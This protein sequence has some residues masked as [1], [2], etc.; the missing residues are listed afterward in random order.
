VAESIIDAWRE[1]ESAAK[2]ATIGVGEGLGLGA[3]QRGKRD[4]VVGVHLS[5][6]ERGSK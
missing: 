6:E 1:G 2:I 3:I 4:I 5:G